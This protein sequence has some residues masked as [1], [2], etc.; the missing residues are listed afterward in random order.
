MSLLTYNYYGL[1]KANI[2]LS[3]HIQ[4]GKKSVTSE[5]CGQL[6]VQDKTVQIIMFKNKHIWNKCIKFKYT[7]E[8][9][10]H[11]YFWSNQSCFDSFKRVYTLYSIVQQQL[12]SCS[13]KYKSKF[14][15]TGKLNWSNKSWLCLLS[16]AACFHLARV[17]LRDIW[18]LSPVHNL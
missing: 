14:T 15:R 6:F 11:G 5:L 17:S 2:S 9:R 1:L 8:A 4:E 16:V 13:D 7:V 10:L 18:D 3:N 12:Q